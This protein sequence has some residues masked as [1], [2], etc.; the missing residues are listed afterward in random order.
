MAAADPRFAEGRTHELGRIYQAYQARLREGG[1]Y[2]EE[3]RFWEALE[4]MRAGRRAPF[5][6]VARVLVDGFS[7]FTATQMHMLW[8]IAQWEG[9]R[10]YDIALTLDPDDPQRGGHALTDRTARHLD[11]RMGATLPRETL[12]DSEAEAT[13]PELVALSRAVFAR[14]P[15]QL[16]GPPPSCLEVVTCATEREQLEEIARRIKQLITEDGVP[17]EQIG[18][19]FRS[20]QGVAPLLCSTFDRYGIPAFVDCP[21][22][23][24]SSPAVRFLLL[25]LR[26]ASEDFRRRDVAD[27]VGSP[28]FDLRLGGAAVG[29]D[30][31][32]LTTVACLHGLSR[33]AGIIRGRQSWLER[34]QRLQRRRAG[35][36]QAEPGEDDVP[37]GATGRSPLPR[38][39]A[40]GGGSNPRPTGPMHDDAEAIGRL[41][42]WLAAFFSLFDNEKRTFAEGASWLLS[43][44]GALG[45]QQMG[46]G[47]E[48]PQSEAAGAD[49][50]FAALRIRTH[51]ENLRALEAALESMLAVCRLPEAQREVSGEQFEAQLRQLW[52]DVTFQPQRLAAGRVQVL[53]AQRARERRFAHLFVA[54]LVEGAF[55]ARETEHVFYSEAERR[56]LSAAGIG[57]RPLAWH[58]AAESY[59]FHSLLTSATERLTLLYSRGTPLRAPQLPSQYLDEVLY[60]T[61]SGGNAA[62]PA[63]PAK[64]SAPA[65]ACPRELAAAVVPALF[66]SADDELGACYDACLAAT[67]IALPLAVS[68]AIIERERDSLRAPG[69][70]DGVL[71]ADEAVVADLQMRFGTD[72]PFTA[73]TLQAFAN[74]PF[75]FFV[76]HVLGVAE[77]EEPELGLDPATEGS[78]AHRALALLYDPTAVRRT[79]IPA[80]RP[81]VADCVERALHHH[82]RLNGALPPPIR[83]VAKERLER[84]LPA[85]AELLETQW[86]GS[87]TLLVEKRFG[88]PGGSPEL[89]IAHGGISFVLRGR[90]DRV[91]RAE[92]DTPAFAVLDYKRSLAGVGDR[93]KG[94]DGEQDFQ[95]PVYVLAAQLTTEFRDARCVGWGYCRFRRPVA[96]AYHRD[97]AQ[98]IEAAVAAAKRAMSECVAAIRR[99]DFCAL[100]RRDPNAEVRGDTS[101]HRFDVFRAERKGV[102][103]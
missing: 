41:L 11:R 33:E 22:E 56:T 58:E 65:A 32:S 5:E 95:L 16:G 70:F 17:P 34:L 8:E 90:V 99:G 7:D 78:L 86:P 81:S 42:T 14:E 12:L 74:C 100:R 72:V 18:V 87:E 45:L 79:G 31:E 53:D 63:S 93:K 67:P 30:G 102:G 73:S 37:V 57:L 64:V 43:L 60:V 29:P 98:G 85:V 94:L 23:V 38:R 88:L 52:Q 39:A 44:A 40:R 54:G 80:G 68:S 92:V 26:L 46:R 28:W 6:A 76:E 91:D 10:Q 59:L 9:L 69:E 25:P 13:P 36:R 2:D 15:Q 97:T 4:A 96:L 1:V 35:S 62:E 19:V 50:A 66:E 83:N 89:R 77:L 103:A 48:P 27:L 75:A 21:Q 82:E 51:G 55:P 3:G 61:G 84:N 71:S 20:L 49:E 101:G 47:F 24:V